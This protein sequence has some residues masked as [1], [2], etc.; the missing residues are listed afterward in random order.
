MALLTAI[1]IV[2]AAFN[3]IGETPIESFDDDGESEQ[4]ASLTRT[5][6]ASFIVEAMAALKEHK[7]DVAE[8][9]FGTPVPAWHQ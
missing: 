5:A 6:S 1:D 4:D 9:M 7:P 3:R 2:N 8:I